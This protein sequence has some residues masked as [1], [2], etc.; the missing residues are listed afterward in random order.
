MKRILFA[1]FALLPLW[2]AAD[3]MYKWVDDKGVTHYSESPPPADAKGKKATKV[4][5]KPNGPA[6]AGKDNW[7]ERSDAARDKQIQASQQQRQQQQVQSQEKARK[8]MACRQALQQVT[9]LQQARPVYTVNGKGER[10]Y[11]EDADRAQRI[12]DAQGVMRK[13]C[14]Q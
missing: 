13:N 8:D 7:K 1:A 11:V 4:D 3:G 12:A 5:I 2:A 9:T 10:V 6:G 14:E